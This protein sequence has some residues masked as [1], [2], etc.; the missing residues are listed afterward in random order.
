MKADAATEAAVQAVLDRLAE[1]YRTR[2]ATLLQAV[3]APDPDLV[4]FSPG[5]S[6][7]FVGIS[8]IV[9]KARS[10]WARSESASLVCREASIS[11]AGSVA[12]AAVDADFT[13]RAAGAETTLPVHITFVLERRDDEWRIAHAHYSTA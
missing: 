4:M 6:E 3:F 13:V 2:D 9:T 10:D 12:W 8:E 1:V 7:R 11:A 5:A